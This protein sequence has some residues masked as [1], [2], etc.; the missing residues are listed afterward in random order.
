MEHAESDD[1]SLLLFHIKNAQLKVDVEWLGAMIC[2]WP[3][4]FP[5][6]DD[7]AILWDFIRQFMS[8]RDGV[9]YM[10][11]TGQPVT[12]EGSVTC[13]MRQM[14]NITS[15]EQV[16]GEWK[17][18]TLKACVD[19]TPNAEPGDS[20]E[21]AIQVNITKRL[22]REAMMIYLLG[23]LVTAWKNQI[24]GAPSTGPGIYSDVGLLRRCL[25]IAEENQTFGE[26]LEA[27]DAYAPYNPAFNLERVIQNDESPRL[28]NAPVVSGQQ[29]PQG[30]DAQ[31]AAPEFSHSRVRW[32]N[33]RRQIQQA[34]N[35]IA[36]EAG[37]AE[38]QFINDVDDEEVPP[39]IGVLFGYLERSYLQLRIPPTDS[40]DRMS[41]REMYGLRRHG[42]VFLPDWT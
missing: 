9:R 6:Q 32:T 18:E 17:E 37:A 41:L 39:G 28:E 29:L 25:S 8:W 2:A 7:G 34:W 15:L 10:P 11:E 31:P 5:P 4:P 12:T 13:L 42:Q 19:L 1:P 16:L 26:L 27:H 20:L 23:S 3:V 30:R 36:N 22:L 14:K 21:A 33:S 38:I 24:S 35:K 40:P